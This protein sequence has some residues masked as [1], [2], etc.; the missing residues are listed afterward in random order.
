MAHSLYKDKKVGIWGLGK[1][2]QSVLS[3]IAPHVASL[4]VIESAPL[5]PEQQKLLQTHNAQL[6]PADYLSQFLELNDIIIPSPGVDLSRY[7]EWSGKFVSELALFERH[8]TQKTIAI[9][10]SVGKTTTVTL[11]TQLLNRCGIKAIAV[12]NI[13]TP[14]LDILANQ[15]NYDVI[16][17]ELSSFQLEQPHTFAPSLA[18]ITNIF[19]NHLDRHTTMEQYAHAK[20]QL[21]AHQTDEQWAIIPFEF[22]DTFIDFTA[23]QK[24]VWLSQ[25][26]YQDYITEVLSDVTFAQNWRLIFALL[27][28]MGIEPEQV[29]PHCTS[30]SI[31]EHRFERIGTYLGITFYNDSKAT[32]S[33]STLESLARCANKPVILFLGG[34]SKGVDRSSLIKQLPK[35]CKSVICFGKEAD[36]LQQL[37]AARGL[38]SSSH[39]TLESA[40]NTCTAQASEGDTVLFSPAGASYD[41][42]KNYEERGNAFKKLVTQFSLSA[43]DL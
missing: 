33:E 13:G 7:S 25:D 32:I 24:V 22:V 40:W 4:T 29:L 20:G 5:S 12:G 35:T 2:G 17:L 31:P 14:M 9:T 36:T 19:P 42:F 26:A 15:K 27:N 38:T 11:L 21:L 34:I 23:G 30:L 18:A 8:V 10:G 39:P 41:L 28:E 1:T 6:V 37:C 3:F 43:T 16:V